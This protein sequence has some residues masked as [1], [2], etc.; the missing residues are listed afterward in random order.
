MGLLG[1]FYGTLSGKFY[2]TYLGGG[3]GP[4]LILGP[5]E[6]AHPKPKEKTSEEAYL[7]FPCIQRI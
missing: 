4:R 2:F 1:A 6:V 5:T 3:D 7:V